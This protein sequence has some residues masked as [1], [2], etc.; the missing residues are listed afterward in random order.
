[1]N[2][3]CTFAAISSKNSMPLPRVAC[4]SRGMTLVPSSSTY[5]HTYL[6]SFL[7]LP[8]RVVMLVS[9]GVRSSSFSDDWSIS[10]LCSVGGGTMTAM[11]SSSCAMMPSM[12][13]WLA[14]SLLRASQLTCQTSPTPSRSKLSAQTA[15]RTSL[16][17]TGQPSPSLSWL[18]P[19][20]SVWTPL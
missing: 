17:G 8:R 18:S 10:E 16:F 14:S 12:T 2:W 3:H 1:M 7:T 11:M 19:L 4:W 13:S 6:S 5:I 15:G 20:S 9:K